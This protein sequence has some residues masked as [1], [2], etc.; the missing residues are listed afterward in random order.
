MCSDGMAPLTRRSSVK[1]LLYE[2]GR[3]R[4]RART[5]TGYR[6]YFLFPESIKAASSRSVGEVSNNKTPFI[7]A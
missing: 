6:T 3:E 7:D 5:K 2:I 4:Q 1:V